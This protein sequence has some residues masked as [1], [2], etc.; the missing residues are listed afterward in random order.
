[1][2]DIAY[3][4]DKGERNY[5][6]DSVC[7]LQGENGYFFVLCD[8]LGGHGGGD[9]ASNLVTHCANGVFHANSLDSETLLTQTVSVAQE[10]LFQYQMQ[11][12]KESQCKTTIAMLS[13]QESRARWAHVGDSRVYVFQKHKLLTRTLDH[14]VPQ[15]LVMQGEIKEKDIRHHEDRNRLIRVMGADREPPSIP[16]SEP[17]GL[18]SPMAFLLCSDGYWEWILEKEMTTHLKTAKNAQDWLDCMTATVKK[19]GAGQGMDNFSAIGVIYR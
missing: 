5:N 9:V 1:M 17:L 11:H 10:E 14:S 19:R 7:I 15:M 16:I 3:C 12:H 13:I 6:E 18:K 8:G 2:L 4:S